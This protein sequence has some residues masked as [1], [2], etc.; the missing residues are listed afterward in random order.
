LRRAPDPLRPAIWAPPVVAFAVLLIVWQLLAVHDRFLLPTLGAVAKQLVDDPTTYLAN[1]GDTLS[2]A[3]PGVAISYAVALLLALAM[4]QSRLVTRAVLPIAV[5]L[6]V[7]PLI[8]IAPAL[9]VAFSFSRTPKIVLVALITFFP[10]LIN[11]LA[12][13]RSAD[14]QAMEVLETLHASRWETL[15]RLQLPSSLPYLFAAA[16]VVVPL[17]I[18]G[19]AVAE[20][21]SPGASNGLGFVIYM[22][23]EQ[24]QLAIAWAGIVTLVVFGL[25]MMAIV[26][27]SEGRVLHWRGFR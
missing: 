21:V 17:S 16:R 27:V 23:S 26:V 14:P 13:L 22:A 5:V 8:A 9:V 12:G 1:A 18:V 2:E 3:I 20:M 4:T 10:A 24:S 11:S 7:T 6:N 19:A 25:M 15:W